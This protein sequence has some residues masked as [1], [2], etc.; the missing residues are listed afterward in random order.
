M[1]VLIS[2]LSSPD[3]WNAARLSMN[4]SVPEYLSTAGEDTAT[5]VVESDSAGTPYRR[6]SPTIGV[7]LPNG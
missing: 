5:I 7:V 4:I 6:V 2:M 3:G 1:I